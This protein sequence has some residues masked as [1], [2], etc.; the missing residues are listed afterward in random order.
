MNLP[1]P[2]FLA[3]AFMVLVLFF[4][5]PRAV[6]FLYPFTLTVLPTFRGMIGMPVYLFDVAAVLILSIVYRRS[7]RRAWPKSL[8]PWPTAIVTLLIVFGFFVPAIRYGLHP[9]IVWI[10]VHAYLALIFVYVGSAF[11]ADPGLEEYKSAFVWGVLASLAALAV[12]AVAERGSPAVAGFFNS[13]YYRDFTNTSMGATLSGSSSGDAG[14]QLISLRAAAGFG[15]PNNL[16][17]LAV[18]SAAWVWFARGGRLGA[19]AWFFCTLIVF[20]TVSRQALLGTLL[21]LVGFGLLRGGRTTWQT[22]G[23]FVLI[24][25]LLPIIMQLPQFES[26]S[27]RLGRLQQGADEANVSARLVDGP[28]R[29]FALIDRRNDV[30]L[31]GVGLDVGKLA[32]KN[33]DVDGLD[34]GFASTAFLLALYYFGVIGFLM[35]LAYWLS[36]IWGSLQLP[37]RIMAKAFPL[38]L[39]STFLFFVDNAGLVSEASMA[40]F[41]LV[42][43]SIFA[44]QAIAQRERRAIRSVVAFSAGREA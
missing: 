9:E 44:M 12:I 24:P 2:I 30:L 27:E 6:F 23:I 37:R 33:I 15:S 19:L 36:C 31:F 43:G 14:A 39:S 7:G 17:E 32:A 1:V 21:C 18:L 8:F 3:Y 16:G 26:W 42:A 13:I 40:C 11:V 28:E 38:A 20:A 34:T 22:L 41:G 10:V 25:L 5:Q 4:L 35:Y 29:L